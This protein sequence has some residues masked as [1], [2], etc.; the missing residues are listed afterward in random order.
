VVAYQKAFVEW[1]KEYKK[2]FQ[3]WDNNRNPLPILPSHNFSISGGC[4][5][6]IL[7]IHDEST[8]FQNDERK[9]CWAHHDSQAL[10]KTKG[11]GQ[12]IMVSDFLTAEWGCLYDEQQC[13]P[14]PSPY[15][16]SDIYP[17][18]LMS[19]LSQER[20]MMGSSIWIIY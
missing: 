19:S 1:W 4:F 7:V 9:T 10:P 16:C 17:K 3:L 15:A 8:F 14:F 12:S 20:I 5:H 18:R 11:D 6:L 2:R 13:V